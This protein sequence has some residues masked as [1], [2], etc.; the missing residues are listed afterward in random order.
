[1]PFCAC[2][3]LSCQIGIRFLSIFFIFVINIA[4]IKQIVLQGLGVVPE[5]RSFFHRNDRNGTNI[6]KKV[7]TRP[8]LPAVG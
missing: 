1:M 3:P 7:G 2:D 4:V 6:L 8:G 5:E